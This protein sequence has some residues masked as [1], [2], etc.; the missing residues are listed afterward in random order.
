MPLCGVEAGAEDDHDAHAHVRAETFAADLPER[1]SN[2][3][4]HDRLDI[5]VAYTATAAENWADRGGAHAAIRH[6]VDYMKMVFRNNDLPVEPHLV[7]IVQ[8]S[9]ALDRAG[10][11]LPWY[12]FRGSV[13]T[14]FDRESELRRLGHEH[15]ADLL[16][17][18]TGERALLV[19]ACG[20]TSVL[21]KAQRRPRVS[22]V[23]PEPGPRTT[24]STA[25][26]TASRSST[27]SATIWAPTTIQ[28]TSG[29]RIACSGRTPRPHGPGR[30]A[31]P[32]HGNELQGPGRAVLLDSAAPALGR[33]SRHRGRA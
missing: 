3:Q 13:T 9:A 2:P 16:H 14:V 1:V 20:R 23:V 6:A 32:R 29:I 15:R 12:K 18:F 22:P 24:R 7:H 27:R 4:S 19:S 31:E 17:L 26:T 10:R 11:D 8:A 33:G 30:H 21:R 25:R 28:P 5:L